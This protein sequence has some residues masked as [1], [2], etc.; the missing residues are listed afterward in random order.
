MKHCSA[1]QRAVTSRVT[2]Q[3]QFSEETLLWGMF[4]EN[5]WQFAKLTSGFEVSFLSECFTLVIASL[6]LSLTLRNPRWKTLSST[7]LK[8]CHLQAMWQVQ[9]SRT[10]VPSQACQVF[11]IFSVSC[12]E[13]CSVQAW[14]TINWS[15]VV[16][17]EFIVRSC[18]LS[19]SNSNKQL[20]TRKQA[21]PS[22]LMCYHSN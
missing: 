2:M 10:S 19:N 6:A 17:W 8:Q 9:V 22:T 5:F 15:W 12:S 11:A 16:A 20:Y 14:W 1:G 21:V 18:L 3:W 13:L 4:L 7:I